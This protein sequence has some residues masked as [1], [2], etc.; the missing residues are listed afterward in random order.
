MPACVSHADRFSVNLEPFNPEPLNPERLLKP[1][2]N[3][4]TT[5]SEIFNKISPPFLEFLLFYT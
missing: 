3:S 4:D 5:F 2:K 1:V